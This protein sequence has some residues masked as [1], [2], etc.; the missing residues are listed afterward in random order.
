MVCIQSRK[1]RAEMTLVFRR[2]LSFSTMEFVC[3]I[4]FVT[5]SERLGR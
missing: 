5:I 3:P 1:L 2:A 4:E